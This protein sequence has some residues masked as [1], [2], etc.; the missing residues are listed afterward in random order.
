MSKIGQA[1]TVYLCPACRQP[2]ESAVDASEC[3]TPILAYTCDYCET[4]HFE[5]EDA[6]ECCMSSCETCGEKFVPKDREKICPRC[7]V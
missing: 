3:C 2:N 1:S 7:K 4:V 5:I 6:Q